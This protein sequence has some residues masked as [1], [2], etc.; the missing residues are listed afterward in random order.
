MGWLRRGGQKGGGEGRHVEGKAGGGAEERVSEGEGRGCGGGLR[1]KKE[2]RRKRK[3]KRSPQSLP[4]QRLIIGPKVFCANRCFSTSPSIAA[5]NGIVR[6]FLAFH[7]YRVG[8][9]ACPLYYQ[10]GLG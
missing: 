1:K 3:N 10:A 2:G 7:R 6:L 8:E 4:T 5:G 9:F